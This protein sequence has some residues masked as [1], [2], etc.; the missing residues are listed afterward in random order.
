MC[1]GLM[2]RLPDSRSVKRG[3]WTEPLARMRSPGGHGHGWAQAAGPLPP[4]HPL[5]FSYHQGPGPHLTTALSPCPRVSS[6]L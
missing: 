1:V 5:A 6:Q 3:S 4:G 2:S